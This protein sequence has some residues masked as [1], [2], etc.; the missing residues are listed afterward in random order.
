MGLLA[1]DTGKKTKK[2]HMA[3]VSDSCEATPSIGE[4]TPSLDDNILHQLMEADE[5]KQLKVWSSEIER[6]DVYLTAKK[7]SPSWKKV[8][9]RKTVDVEN[10]KVIQIKYI[11]DKD[12]G[13]M[14]EKIENGPL[15]VR[16]YM[17]YL[18]VERHMD[19]I[20]DY[21][22]DPRCWKSEA[23]TDWSKGNVCMPVDDLI[24]TGT[25]D[26]LLSFARELKK[27][28]QIG[29]LDEND[30][31]FCGQ[32]ILKPGA[33]VPVHQDLCIEDLHE[34]LILKGRDAD[35]LLGPDLT[36]YRSVLAKLNW[37]Q[38]RTQFHIR[39]R[40]S[41]CASASASANMS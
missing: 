3:H 31:M 22:I 38:S 33:T 14:K 11:G 4:S 1:A 26:F 8:I 6:R 5:N 30:V 35:P 21:I 7:T 28:F 15:R 18:N 36:E 13:S 12:W 25:D 39:Y 27:S 17:V 20:M 34:A 23:E 24:F 37:L 41:R 29:S 10:G 19:T 40:F 16:T 9:M 32:R 2:H